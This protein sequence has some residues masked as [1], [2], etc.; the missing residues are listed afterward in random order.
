MI[1]CL[2]SAV[3]QCALMSGCGIVNGDQRRRTGSGSAL[4]PVYSDTTQL[5]WT[6]R[7]YKR[8]FRGVFA[9]TR[10]TYPHFKSNVPS[11]V[12]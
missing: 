2:V 1:H 6:L 8:A 9:M 7:R 11:Y 4:R 5:N 10:F 12:S 3:S